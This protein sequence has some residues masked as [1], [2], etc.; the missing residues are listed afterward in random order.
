MSLSILG[1]KP[2]ALTY[3]GSRRP[4]AR[5]LTSDGDPAAVNRVCSHDRA[6]ELG[7]SCTDQTGDAQNFSAVE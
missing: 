2:K 1:K 5:G 6:C 4:D 7:S 3:G